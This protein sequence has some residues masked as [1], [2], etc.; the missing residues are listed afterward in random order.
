MGVALDGRE[1]KSM[2]VHTGGEGAA[3]VV[4]V[5]VETRNTIKDCA[6]MMAFVGRMDLGKKI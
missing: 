2:G 5:I 6:C 4:A 1:P 3:T